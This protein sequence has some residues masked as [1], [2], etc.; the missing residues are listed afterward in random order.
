MGGES[1]AMWW[2]YFY[3]APSPGS[4]FMALELRP[5][6]LGPKGVHQ[7]RTGNGKQ[8]TFLSNVLIPELVRSCF[9]LFFPQPIQGFQEEPLTVEQSSESFR[10]C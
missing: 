7:E 1:L 8:E 3:L 2:V 5:L 6:T 9:V 4:P 10:K